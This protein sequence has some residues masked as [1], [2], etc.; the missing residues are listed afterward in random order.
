MND[1]NK[2]TVILKVIG[3]ILVVGLI[4]LG[5]N[6]KHIFKSSRQLTRSEKV[7]NVSSQSDYED[8]VSLHDSKSL[9]EA[10][11]KLVGRWY[12]TDEYDDTEGFDENS[13][14][15]SYSFR[16]ESVDNFMP[17]GTEI[18]Q[19]VML[20]YYTIDDYDWS[21]IVTLQFNYIYEGTWTLN[22]D[23]LILK[24]NRFDMEYVKPKRFNK[25]EISYRKDLLTALQGEIPGL[26]KESLKR[27]IQKIVRL[28]DD[29][30]VYEDEDG[31]QTSCVR[32]NN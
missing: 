30:F 28:T 4:I 10:E 13:T 25:K 9:T 21:G 16:L 24:G 12:Y 29:E 3:S 5:R 26:R 8:I 32:L 31:E 27:R 19:G 18:D 2:K 14:V 1:M 22:G 11:R 23:S 15:Q 7:A 17:D 6:A 20:F